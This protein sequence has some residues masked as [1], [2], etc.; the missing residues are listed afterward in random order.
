LDT[1][2]LAII[3]SYCATDFEN[4]FSREWA[5]FCIRNC[6]E[7]CFE[8]QHFI[9]NLKFQDINIVNKEMLD[10]NM[11]INFDF[12]KGKFQLNSEK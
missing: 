10:K 4:V 9:E 6:C 1:G 8:N 7:N 3:L 5:L 2:C 11:K 12:K